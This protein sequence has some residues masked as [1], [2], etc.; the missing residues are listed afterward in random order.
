MMANG[1]LGTNGPRWNGYY[2]GEVLQGKFFAVRF[3]G[4]EC[5]IQSLPSYY[6]EEY[7]LNSLELMAP[8]Y[9]DRFKMQGNRITIS[10]YRDGQEVVMSGTLSN[11]A[12]RITLTSWGNREI[13]IDMNFKQVDLTYGK[14]IG[15]F[16]EEAK[17]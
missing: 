12:K 13:Y 1:R 3:W 9:S 6:T 10:G 17:L 7:I 2:K 15:Y 16:W 5:S 14:Q 8:M 4:D 11:D